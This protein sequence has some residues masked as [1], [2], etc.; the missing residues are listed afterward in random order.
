MWD[1]TLAAFLALAIAIGL[2]ANLLARHVF[3]LGDT[4][5]IVIFALL[6]GVLA[7]AFP[8]LVTPLPKDTVDLWYYALGIATVLAIFA[9]NES[10]RRRLV[11]VSEYQQAVTEKEGL[12]RRLTAFRRTVARPDET[13]AQLRTQSRA[14]ADSLVSTKDYFC[15]C[16]M[17][18]AQCAALPGRGVLLREERAFDLEAREASRDGYAK[19]CSDLVNAKSE[20]VWSELSRLTT[21]S[22][23]AAFDLKALRGSGQRV[24][25]N[26]LQVSVDDV[27]SDLVSVLSGA[28]DLE[29]KRLRLES[30]LAGKASELQRA[31]SRYDDIGRIEDK[32]AHFSWSFAI[33]FLWPYM[34]IS[35]LG[36]KI[37]RVK[38]F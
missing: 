36:L 1:K 26:D 35:L 22:E 17:P 29:L 28:K 7:L 9:N 11:L 12:D 13:F 6:I 20:G 5:A 16:A 10:E 31:R 33:G 18:M 32:M 34:L 23:L 3:G 21:M 2:V 24:F 27:V 30:D 4:G 14:I 15:R 37:A 25:I 38:Y 19:L 8:Q